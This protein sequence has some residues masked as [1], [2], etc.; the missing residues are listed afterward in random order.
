MRYLPWKHKMLKM[1]TQEQC[2]VSN[3]VRGSRQSIPGWK[4]DSNIACLQRYYRGERKLNISKGFV[5]SA[6][7]DK[8][9][10]LPVRWGWRSTYIGVSLTSSN[11]WELPASHVLTLS[12]HFEKVV[13]GIWK[14]DVACEDYGQA[15]SKEI[16]LLKLGKWCL[17]GFQTS[18]PVGDLALEIR[19]TM[20]LR[21]L[22]KQSCWGSGSRDSESGVSSI[23]EKVI[24]LGVW[25]SRFGGRCLFDFGAS[26][27]FRS[28]FSNMS[29]GWACL[30]VY[31]ATK[32]KG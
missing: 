22:R 32:H 15:L 13:C 26:N 28:V 6:L 7:L 5:E 17:F 12:E 2:Q 11:N 1:S 27:L 24:M 14:A 29:K 4:L 23:F 30:L 16:Q 19:I 21:F 8:R 3:Q 18:N 9:K 25:L 10:G 31:L 20:P